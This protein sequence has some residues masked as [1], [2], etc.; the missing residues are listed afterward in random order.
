MKIIKN[1]LIVIYLIIAIFATVCL[2][3][4]N[5]YK[6]TEL[7]EYTFVYVD[8]HTNSD[9]FSKGD[10]AIVSSDF[11]TKVGDEIFFYNAYEK[12][13]HP[14]VAKIVA[15]EVIV[16][17][18]EVTYTLDNEKQISSQFVIGKVDESTRIP[19]VGSAMRIIQSKWGFLFLIV[20]PVLI[21]F[22]YEIYTIIIEVRSNK[23]KVKSETKTENS[24]DK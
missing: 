15:E 17:D 11:K 8:K 24:D 4:T 3:S 19:Y 10:L 7:G 9:T 5:Q 2:I 14:T 20:L 18:K 21:A 12:N 23:V 1:I 13:I 6:V 22:I 16:A